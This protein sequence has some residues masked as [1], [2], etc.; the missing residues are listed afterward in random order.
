MRAGFH[1][2]P[3]AVTSRRVWWDLFDLRLINPVEEGG[4][5]KKTSYYNHRYL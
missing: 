4:E 2:Y 3:G 1:V 5:L